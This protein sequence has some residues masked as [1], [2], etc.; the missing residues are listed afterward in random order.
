MITLRSIKYFV[1]SLS[2]CLAF[3]ASAFAQQDSLS[4]KSDSAALK[5]DLVRDSLRMRAPALSTNLFWAGTATP[6]LAIEVP[7]GKHF[8]IGVSGGLKPWPRWL[9]W[10]FDQDNNA[11]W[12]HFAVLP[13]FR[14]WPR[15]VFDGFYLGADLAYIHYNIGGLSLPFGMYKEL[16]DYRYQGD[17]YGGGLSVGYNWW[18]SRHWTLGLGAG[19]LAGYKN[20]KRYD[21]PHC[22]AELG[23]SNGAVVTPKLDLTIAW[24]IFNLKR[25]ASDKE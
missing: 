16:A 22:G 23:P 10:D 17:F 13:S 24:H 25:A 15:T 3:C 11:K 19:F 7:L 8:S 20:A 12:R 9:A 14:W 6:N 4:F 18:L 1:L 21:C 2:C 5:Q